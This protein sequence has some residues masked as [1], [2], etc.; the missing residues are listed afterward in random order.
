MANRAAAASRRV[1][2]RRQRQTR[3]RA[4]RPRRIAP[5]AARSAVGAGVQAVL[6]DVC[7]S[8][9]WDRGFGGA[10]CWAAEQEVEGLSL[11]SRAFSSKEDPFLILVYSCR[12]TRS[13][14]L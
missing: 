4:A 12:S 7:S 1:A 13:S 3:R 6:V 11:S 9:R 14:V 2:R 10:R 5:S 8:S